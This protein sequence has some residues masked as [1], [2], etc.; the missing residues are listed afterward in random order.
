MALHGYL[1]ER[2]NNMAGSYTCYRLME[3]AAIMG[4]DLQLI[5]IEDIY[6]QDGVLFNNGKRMQPCDFVINR[7]KIGKLREQINALA[8]RT[9]NPSD[10]FAR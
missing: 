9:Y 1:I 7:F 3:E 10:A 5:G 8:R 4:M 2:Y 6:I